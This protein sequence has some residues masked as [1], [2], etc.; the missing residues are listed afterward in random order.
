MSTYQP[1]PPPPQ[2]TKPVLL[3]EAPLP[4][5]RFKPRRYPATTVVKWVCYI[6]AAISLLLW[7]INELLLVTGGTLYMGRALF[8]PEFTPNEKLS[9][10]QMV[11]VLGVIHLVNTVFWGFWIVVFMFLAESVRIALDVQRDTYETAFYT[12]HRGS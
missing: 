3:K 1:P 9:A 11:L 6:L 5:E 10:P 7:L 12:K 2:A 4:R 8:G